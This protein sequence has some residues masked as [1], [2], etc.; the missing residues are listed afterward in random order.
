MGKHDLGRLTK[1]V[2]RFHHPEG[3]ARVWL[4]SGFLSAITVLGVARFGTEQ[5][6]PLPGLTVPWWPLAVAFGLAE[7]F[8]IHLRIDRDAHSFSLSE[9]PLVIGLA[10]AAP[11][12]LVLGQAVGVGAALML[13]RRQR[14]IRTVFNLAQRSVTTTL[15]IS[16]F[17][18]L[19]A[20]SGAGWPAI[21]ATAVLTTLTVDVVSALLINLAIRLSEG[22]GKIFDQVIGPGTIFTIANTALALVAV[23]VMSVNPWGLLLVAAPTITTFLAG[24][25]YSRVQRKHEELTLLQRATRLA[26]TSLDLE[27]VLP[28]L[29]DHVREMFQADI[30][31]LVL[32]P[33]H[34]GEEYLATQLGPG[35]ER[36]ILRPEVPDPARGV[37]ARVSSEREGI[38]LAR[39]IRN[40]ALAAFFEEKG[41]FEAIV[42]PMLSDGDVT[43]MLTVANRL[44]EFA[45]FD[46][47]DLHLL[48]VVANHVCVSVRNAQLV[49][50]LGG[51][52]EHERH[53]GELKDDFV[54]TISH[55]LRTPLTNVQGFIKTLLNPGVA[56]S[57][58]ERLEFLAS[59]D[60]QAER[61]KTL[62]EDLLFTSFV[63]QSQARPVADS[64]PLGDLI[65]Q[66]VRD[67]AGP[68]R[69][70]RIVLSLPD[71][72]PVIRTR[73][74]DVSRLI[75]NLV[76]NALKYSPP[77]D[78]VHVDARLESVGIR[79]S[80]SDHGPGIPSEER[81]RIFDR[82]YQV[83]QG[84]TRRV[85]GAG[86]GLYI[87]RRAAEA[88]GARV[89]LERS[90]S[91]GSTFCVWLPFHT[92]P[93]AGRSGEI[94]LQLV[95]STE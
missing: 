26:E 64:L 76:D 94:S 3:E 4:L 16:L 71:D 27:E 29:L 35:D 24:Q 82:F 70:D 31:E 46:E 87:C 11:A 41:I 5:P 42:V 47:D 79:V 81:D 10:Y 37:W 44:G 93:E 55:E 68:E 61:L 58:E 28:P 53:V 39:P 77:H 25:A 34:P 7:V 14:T 40:G 69:I 86:M 49:E 89:W 84:S 65:D 17:A 88:L 75:G 52:L 56:L 18:A 57:P 6:S 2:R 60:R 20:R 13:H 8:V 33:E 23:M 83:D 66:V 51:A 32:W 43:G 54:A 62:I 85:G 78:G 95:S 48:Q 21:W 90:G 80:I 92:P 9:I 30:A 1:M 73:A 91:K 63:E 50:Q 36:S 12:A 74:E 59:A 38:L 72:L 45:T 15:A 19:H 22:G 67:R